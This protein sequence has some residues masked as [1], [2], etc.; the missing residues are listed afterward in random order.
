M[1]ASPP[2]GAQAEAQVAEAAVPPATTDAVAAEAV[3]AGAAGEVPRWRLFAQLALSGEEIAA[4]MLQPSATLPDLRQAIALAAGERK[5]I[6]LVF[7]G[8]KLA[9]VCSLL[10]AGLSDGSTVSVFRGG[11]PGWTRICHGDANAGE[12]S[13]APLVWDL[14]MAEVRALAQVA[15]RVRIQ[16]RGD[17]SRALESLPGAYPIEDVRRGV[18][19]GY[20]RWLRNTDV[21]S[22]WEVPEGCD[23]EVLGGLEQKLWHTNLHWNRPD[24]DKLELKIYHCCDNGDGIHW[25]S[26]CCGW[27]CGG[28]TDLELYIDA[29]TT[30]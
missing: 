24:Y 23:I 12:A 10:E 27:T 15:T 26:T 28:S 13:G 7:E 22:F 3:Q 18:P 11:L 30:R 14:H 16:E 1:E 21:R 20:Q 19:I 5:P 17:P 29:E 9:G 25:D 6:R 8:R 4:V 2:L